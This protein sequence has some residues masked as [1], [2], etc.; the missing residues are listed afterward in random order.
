LT[1]RDWDAATYERVSDPQF[2]WGVEVLDRLRLRGDESVLDAGC[3]AGRVTAELARRL[4]RGRVIAVDA[5]P[6][7]VERSRAAL[8]PGAQVFVADL[9]ELRLDEPVD[10]ILSTAV[11]HWIPDH[12]RL[13]E[14][15][16]AALK[17]GGRLVAQCG[18]EG[19]V[20]RFHARLWEVARSAPF[21]EH[22]DGWAG[23][24]NFASPDET[25]A[26]L[27]RAGFGD[28]RCSLEPRPFVPPEPRDFMRTVCL[29]HHLERLPEGLRDRFVHAVHDHVPKPVELDYVRLNI[30]ARR[31]AT[32]PNPVA[33]P[34]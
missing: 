1:T 29:G 33:V 7:M 34:T 10:A 22:F 6:S 30:D 25:A 17:P 4:P 31:P 14:R 21:A 19:N 3:G 23:P 32:G 24:W 26:R 8:G 18:G 12:D 5:S 20:K 28:V 16:H 27:E 13:F 2:R 9:A 15:L 11:F